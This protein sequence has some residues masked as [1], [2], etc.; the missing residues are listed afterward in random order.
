[1]HALFAAV[2]AHLPASDAAESSPR[3]V[4]V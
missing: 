4:P 1:V 3:E 2:D